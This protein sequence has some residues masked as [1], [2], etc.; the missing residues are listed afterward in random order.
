MRFKGHKSDQGQIRSVRV[1]SHL[2][3]GTPRRVRPLASSGM[4]L[5][6]EIILLSWGVDG[7]V[8]R[9]CLYLRYFLLVRP[10][11]PIMHDAG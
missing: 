1:R 4:L 11:E 8:L 9:L 2:A 6:G 10:D 5:T 3:V 7:K